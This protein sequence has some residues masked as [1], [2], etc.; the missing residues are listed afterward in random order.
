MKK[1]RIGNCLLVMFFSA[2]LAGGL[3][4]LL[5]V[6]LVFRGFTLSVTKFLLMVLVLFLLAALPWI[7]KKTREILA[8]SVALLICVPLLVCFLCW[9]TVSDDA[10]YHAVDNGKKELYA[11]HRVMLFVPHQDDD[12]NV[13]GGV[14]EE[15]VKYGSEVYVVFSTNGDYHDIADIRLREAVNVM[16]T[17]GIPEENVI[18][19]GYGDGWDPKGCHLYN[20]EPD[21]AI[22]S[23][24]GYAKTYGI[25]GHEAYREGQ[26]YTLRNFLNDIESVIL[27]FKP[28]LIYCVDWD[29]HADHR[30]LSL[31]F[32]KV[33]GKILKE[34][35]DYRPEVLKGYAY[36][37]A[38]EAVDDFHAE[39]L[40]STQNV[41]E[42]PIMQ[43]PQV[44][45]WQD[46][47]RRPVHAEGLSRSAF[48]G[49]QSSL[50][51]LYSSAN[52]VFQSK[53]IINSDKVFWR[54]DT[55]SLCYQAQVQASSGEARYL[56]DFMLLESNDLRAGMLACCDGTWVPERTDD[57]KRLDVSFR[58]PVAIDR[59]VLY[60]HPDP[61]VNVLNA[62]IQFE[63]GTTIETGALDPGGAA[64]TIEFDRK[65][66]S[67]FAVEL[68]ELQGEA[69]LT[70][71]EAFGAQERQEPRFVK[72]MDENENF[73]YDYWI[74]PEGE[75]LFSLYISGM[76]DENFTVSCV[77]DACDA[78][79]EENGLWVHCPEGKSCIVTVSSEDGSCSDS[80]YISNPSRVERRWKQFWLNIEKPVFELCSTEQI[81]DRIIVCRVLRRVLDIIQ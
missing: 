29:S 72:I 16:G 12:I 13:L 44:Y 20:T 69:G 2:M 50:L 47:I 23:A 73:A 39:N 26:L 66:S 33:M 46:R 4:V 24:A 3:A 10:V 57:E 61:E 71:L 17:V 75:Q 36:A 55:E 18:F 53:R 81:Q 11:G 35:P 70:E 22:R 42:E 45:R 1:H 5:D 19:L 28:D 43:K 62:K 40:L 56:T 49:G 25:Q 15:Y 64:T 9:K 79:L 63:D 32:E 34:E 60:D 59:I 8:V 76:A 51:R 37:T 80:V 65:T 58:E 77:G 38:W 30:A 68:T 74:A 14:M 67:S 31:S 41:F 7:R 54:R 52:A 78:G 48:S 27:E 21:K 6:I